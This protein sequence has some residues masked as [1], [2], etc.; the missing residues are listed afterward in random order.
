MWTISLSA[1]DPRSVE[2]STR[3]KYPSA[4]TRFLLF[5]R[6][7]SL[8]SCP[9]LDL[10]LA[11]HDLIARLRVPLHLDALDVHRRPALDG[12]DDVHHLVH[13]IELRFGLGLDIREPAVAV[14]GA[15]GLQILDE[16]RAVEIISRLR[17]HHLPEGAPPPEGLDFAPVVVAFVHAQL[18]NL[19]ARTLV[20]DDGD[21][22]AAPIGRQH[23]PRRA[24]LH[25]EVALI[26]VEGAQHQDVPFEDVLAIGPSGPEREEA[27]VARLHRVAELA[28]GHVVVADE[29]DAP[30]RH[31]LVLGDLELDR[32]LVFARGLDLV[33][34]VREEVALLG[35]RILDLLHAPAHRGHAQDR[36]RLDFDGLA[37][38]IV[39]DLV[40]SRRTVIALDVRPF[41][42]DEAKDD[43][44]VVGGKVDLN[45]L[46]ESGV[47]EGVDVAR[48]VLDLEEL[49][50]LLAQVRED[51]VAGD[52]AVPHDLEGRDGQP[53]GL[54]GDG[55]R[56][57]DGGLGGRLRLCPP[58]GRGAHASV[59][60]RGCR[61]RIDRGSRVAGGGGVRT[62]VRRSRAPDAE[63]RQ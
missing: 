44:L 52:A 5:S 8:K 3:S 50:G 53:F 27:P 7:V 18:A 24:D 25:A 43:A 34:D 38:L 57:D 2:M 23:H 16:L 20:D 40:V 1:A 29:G 42:D 31:G 28:V 54:F 63:K 46:E 61:H 22:D 6:C 36:V 39:L 56:K 15:Y 13:G 11:A 17:A 9:L 55:R 59:G 14:Q 10:E 32:D 35:V 21:V 51:V 58:V 4:V 62:G 47:P 41:T 30:H 49:T 48:E 19:E 12:D 45:V 60:R 26:V 33:V 37:E